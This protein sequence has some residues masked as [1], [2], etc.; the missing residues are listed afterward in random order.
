MLDCMLPKDAYIQTC[1]YTKPLQQQRVALSNRWP[2]QTCFDLTSSPSCP[3]Q[4]ERLRLRPSKWRTTWQEAGHTGRLIIIDDVRGPEHDRLLSASSGGCRCHLRR[5]RRGLLVSGVRA[6]RQH[7]KRVWSLYR[8]FAWQPD[9]VPVQRMEVVSDARQVGP[10][11][12]R[13][14]TTSGP[15]G[16]LQ[17]TAPAF[18]EH[19]SITEYLV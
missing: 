15:N 4:R 10:T 11:A 9:T 19:M 7:S 2:H 13:S 12:L 1:S 16:W 3:S 17:V 18:T 14:C 8:V 6:C 5:V